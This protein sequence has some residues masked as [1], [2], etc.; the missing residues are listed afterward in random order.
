MPKQVKK[1]YIK[2]DKYVV[3]L[4]TGEVWNQ[5]KES[6]EWLEEQLKIIDSEKNRK[7]K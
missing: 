1:A 5:S 2:G 7:D 4:D 3:K 6:K